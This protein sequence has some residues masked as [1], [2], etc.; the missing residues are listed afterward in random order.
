M[1][2]LLA[3]VD[4]KA[5]AYE[6]LPLCG[7]MD[8]TTLDA[9]D[10]LGF[11]P[12]LAHF[13]M[14]FAD[15]YGLVL[16]EEPA[17]DRYQEL[18]NAHTHEDGGH[19]KWYLADLAALSEDPPQRFSDTL[20]FVWSDA[21]AKSR[22]L[23]YRMCRLGYG[24]SSLERLVLVHCIEAVGKVSL[25]HA[26]PLGREL[27]TRLGRQLLYFGAHH[28]DTEEDHTLEDKSVRASLDS[29][30]LDDS[31]RPKLHAL[32]DEA[33]AAF[34]EFS[35]ELLRFARARLAARMRATT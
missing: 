7:F 15:L 35:D 29:I 27:A 31:I 26:A 30:A 22:L 24:A 21:S 1:Q 3:Y 14:T 13:V 4:E 34:T 11:V 19:W 12:C 18:V 23:S 17:R 32:I 6:R 33:F 5:L 28:L 2:K 16:R 9:R 25:S 20:R 8:D 10:R